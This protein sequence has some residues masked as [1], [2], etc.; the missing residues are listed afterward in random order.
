ME[1][2]ERLSGGRLA[3]RRSRCGEGGR[4]RGYDVALDPARR[5]VFKTVRMQREDLAVAMIAREG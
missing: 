3:M 1:D 5:V 4:L 2:V